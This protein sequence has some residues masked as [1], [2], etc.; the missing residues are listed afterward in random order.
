PASVAGT[1]TSSAC[2]VPWSTTTCS[3]TGCTMSRCTGAGVAGATGGTGW[4]TGT[5]TGG[6]GGTTLS[7]IGTT[8]IPRSD[9]TARS[10]SPAGISSNSRTA[11]LSAIAPAP[12]A[13]RA[14]SK[15]GDEAVENE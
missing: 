3:M 14:T 4:T 2:S 9:G 11:T 1:A 6:F 15:R 13:M 12:A 7:M 5:G 10:G 8:T